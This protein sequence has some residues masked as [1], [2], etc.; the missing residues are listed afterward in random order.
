MYMET[1]SLQIPCQKLFQIKKIK[2][3]VFSRFLKSPELISICEPI[4]ICIYMYIS[5]QYTPI[6]ERTTD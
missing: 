2:N 5:R 3:G 1:M 6:I 4:Y